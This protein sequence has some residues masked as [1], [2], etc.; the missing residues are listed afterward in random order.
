MKT[1]MEYFNKDV[2]ITIKSGKEWIGFVET[3]TPAIDSDDELE[4]IG[5]NTSEGLI[6][7]TEK[8]I[9]SIEIL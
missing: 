7:F 1:L 4:E 6:G 2:K 9:K 8:D 5:V 3:F